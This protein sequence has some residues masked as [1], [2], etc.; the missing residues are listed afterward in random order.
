MKTDMYISENYQG[1]LLIEFS[2]G[3]LVWYEVGLVDKKN[4][5][6]YTREHFATRELAKEYIDLMNTID[7]AAKQESFMKCAIC[8]S[9]FSVMEEI[10]PEE[11]H[12]N[13]IFAQRCPKC[14]SN[15]INL[16]RNLN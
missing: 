2:R 13:W 1:H 16:I 14:E 6:S 15:F 10:I 3:E 11:K 9:D 12:S 5:V 4:C 7:K 8:K